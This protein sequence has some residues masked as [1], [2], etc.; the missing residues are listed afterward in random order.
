MQGSFVRKRGSTWTVYF[1]VPDAQGQRRQRTKGGFRTKADAQAHLITVMNKIQSGDFVERSKLTVSDYLQNIWLPL[2]ESSLRPT[3]FDSYQRMLKIHVYP[4]IGGVALQRLSATHLDRLYADLLRDG[5]HERPGGLSPKTVRYIHNTLQKA[6]KDAVRKGL[7]SRNVASSADP[8][9]HRQSGSHEIMTWTPAEVRSFLG[10]LKGHRLEAGYILAVTTGMRR[11]EVLGLRWRDV[12]FSN[13]RLA[14]RQTVISVNYKVIIGEPKTAKGRRSIA[15]D[16][17]TV[18]ALQAHKSLQQ[19]DKKAC[20]GPY[21]DLDLVFPKIDGS[22]TNPDFFSQCFDRTVAKLT[23]P[24][25][26]LHDLRHTHATIGLAAGVPPKIMSERLG[27]ATVTFTQDVYMHAIPGMQE[28][29]ARLT[30]S[31]VFG[32][33]DEGDGQNRSA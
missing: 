31:M 5:R 20:E 29:A 17:A 30:A 23:V 1:Y 21:K 8:P 26:R 13:Q 18:A 25:I 4:A 33:G 22:P 14:V 3:T 16:P 6:L 2:V 15:L 28:D 10:A 11:G 32:E 27:H 24:R 7:I 19:A 9:K 12:D